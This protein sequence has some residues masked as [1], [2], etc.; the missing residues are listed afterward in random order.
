MAI[1]PDNVGSESKWRALRERERSSSKLGIPSVFRIV[2]Y[3]HAIPLQ[4]LASQISRFVVFRFFFLCETPIASSEDVIARISV[5][6]ADIRGMPVWSSSSRFTPSPLWNLHC[7]WQS[8]ILAFVINKSS[9]SSLFIFIV[10]SILL[11]DTTLYG[12]SL[13]DCMVVRF[14]KFCHLYLYR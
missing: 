1:L 3:S 14:G 12:E 13:Y 9:S 6:T 5:A 4:R 7:N 8:L 11:S 2:H 10:F